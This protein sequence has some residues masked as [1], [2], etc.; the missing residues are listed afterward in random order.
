MR[1]SGTVGTHAGASQSGTLE[2]AAVAL[3]GA[4]SRGQRTHRHVEIVPA[5]KMVSF[6]SAWSNLRP[7]SLLNKL[8]VRGAN[9]HD[10]R[11]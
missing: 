10:L 5:S 9:L 6:S 7:V 11:Q 4:Q 2:A 3:R 1:I 8:L